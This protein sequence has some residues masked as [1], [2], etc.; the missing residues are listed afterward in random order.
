ML[1]MFISTFMLHCRRILG[2][3]W[4]KK[5]K[6][7]NLTPENQSRNGT[8]LYY[9][10]MT[11]PTLQCCGQ[12]KPHKKHAWLFESD[13]NK[14]MSCFKC[15]SLFTVLV[16]NVQWAY[17]SET[18]SIQDEPGNLFSCLSAGFR[19]TPVSVSQYFHLLLC[20]FQE[21]GHFQDY[22]YYAHQWDSYC[23]HFLYCCDGFCDGVFYGDD[24]LAGQ[25]YHFGY[26][27]LDS[28]LFDANL[29]EFKIYKSFNKHINYVKH[30]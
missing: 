17:P 18:M 22:C 16:K 10:S 19:G 24:E 23:F 21:F 4:T 25:L 26:C 15:I 1:V 28:S 13:V 7:Y 5:I 2:R 6:Q 29:L 30:I 9:F 3:I 20:L 11:G 8:W 27:C 14:S 12:K